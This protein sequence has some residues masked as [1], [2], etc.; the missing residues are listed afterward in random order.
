MILYFLITI[1]AEK[2]VTGT[3]V[4]PLH[5]GTMD[6]AAHIVCDQLRAQLLTEGFFFCCCLRIQI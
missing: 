4:V 6:V 5:L 1:L 2:S 3:T